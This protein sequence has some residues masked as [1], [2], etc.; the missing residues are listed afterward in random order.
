[1]RKNFILLLLVF[2][3][4]SSFCQ[5]VTLND[6]NRE[7][8]KTTK[9][10]MLVLGG[11]AAANLLYSGISIT[12][13]TGNDK[14]FHEMNL[15][16]GG[17][18]IGLAT[19]GYLGAKKQDGLTY[20]QSMK[21][22]MGVEKIFLFNAGLDVAYIAGGFYLKEKAKNDLKNTDRF[23]GYGKSVVLQGAGLLLFDGI[24]YLLH[25]TH[26]KQLNK[27]AEKIQIVSTGNGI[28]CIVKL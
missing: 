23:E 9:Q 15:I 8:I 22:Q 7:R 11:W 25:N 21:K 6:F 27:M 19:I 26:G 17:I 1:M 14:Y 18:N 12:A 3:C 24:M 10:S 2:S 16:W 13:A 4:S 28:G 5:T 20:A